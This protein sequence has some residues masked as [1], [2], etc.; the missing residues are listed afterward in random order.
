V[1]WLILDVEALDGRVVEALGT[2]KPV[3][4]PCKLSLSLSNIFDA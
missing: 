1:N 4:Q 3:V 2:E